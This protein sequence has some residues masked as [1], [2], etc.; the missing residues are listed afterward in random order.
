MKCVLESVWLE[1]G[2]A[3]EKPSSFAIFLPSFQILAASSTKPVMLWAWVSC[4]LSESRLQTKIIK[5]NY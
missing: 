1:R 5:S 4:K 2:D 3:G